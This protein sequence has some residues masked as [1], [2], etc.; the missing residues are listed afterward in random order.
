MVKFH[1]FVVAFKSISVVG[2]NGVV[3]LVKS[4]VSFTD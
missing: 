3:T 4:E 1:R 2:T